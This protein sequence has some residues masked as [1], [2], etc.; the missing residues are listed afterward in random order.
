MRVSSPVDFAAVVDD[1]EVERLVSGQSHDPHHLLGA[2]SERDGDRGRVV[3]RGWRP[4][5]VGM[6]ILADGQR[7]EMRCLH[8]AGLFAGAVDGAG[9]PDYR[10]EMTYPDGSVVTVDDPY[11]YWPTLGRFDLHLLG[12][13]RHEGLW[14]HLG[15]QVYL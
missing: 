9:T 6:V 11:R 2:H 15:A 1:A 4:D 3:I 5:A 12:E 8:P 7:I 10:L 13:G 14:R